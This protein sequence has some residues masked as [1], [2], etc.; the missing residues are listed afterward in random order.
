MRRLLIFLVFV[1][2]TNIASGAHDLSCGELSFKDCLSQAT[3]RQRHTVSKENYERV[4]SNI[5]AKKKFGVGFKDC[6][7]PYHS[8]FH[9]PRVC[10][11]IESVKFDCE[12]PTYSI[13]S[14]ENCSVI[15]AYDLDVNLDSYNRDELLVDEPTD[16][17][18]AVVD[19]ECQA[20]FEMEGSANVYVYN[21]EAVLKSIDDSDSYKVRYSSKESKDI[22]IDI[23]KSF[24]DS[25]T[26]D[27]LVSATCE[28]QKAE[29][30]N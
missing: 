17:V 4:I 28:I 18:H 24:I 25:M 2:A 26:R 9:E 15:V 6:I 21:D 23:P 10:L 13:Y 3:D 30:G 22:K 14:E 1:L 8:I 27:T 12:K 5:Q 16:D 19:V 11:E 20:E 7:N 29:F